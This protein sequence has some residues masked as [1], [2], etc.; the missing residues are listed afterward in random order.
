VQVITFGSPKVG[1][2]YWAA[3]ASNLLPG[4]RITRVVRARDIVPWLLTGDYRQTGHELWIAAGT[5]SATAD[6]F[7]PCLPDSD[8]RYKDCSSS[9]YYR[10][11]LDHSLPGY[12]P[13]SPPPPPPPTHTHTHKPNHKSCHTTPPL[14]TP[15]IATTTTTTTSIIKLFVFHF[16]RA[17]LV[18]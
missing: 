17:I 16:E 9:Q 7:T 10:S 5:G 6:S 18:G 2:I 11:F 14:N 12:P 15:D 13:A 4:R 1:N 3:F 8:Y